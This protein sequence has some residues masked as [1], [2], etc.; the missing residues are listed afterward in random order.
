MGEVVSYVKEFIDELLA[1]AEI[2]GSDLI[3][4]KVNGIIITLPLANPDAVTQAD[5][6]ASIASLVDA[7]PDLL[8]TLNELSAALGD[9]PNFATTM[10]TSLAAKA[11][12]AAVQAELDAIVAS[13][14]IVGSNNQVD[15]YQ[16]VLADAGKVVEI[17]KATAVNLTV[18]T[19]ATVAFPIGTVIEIWQQGAGQVTVVAAG[20]VTIR[21]SE[22][23]LKIYGQYSGAS[24]RKRAA[25]EWVLVGDLVA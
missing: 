6:D 18:P 15:N 11:D 21:S 23:K 3:L 2:V 16:P 10:T 1:N 22:G 17:N 12:D 19:D 14:A 20:G 4:T 25:D 7:S 8:N 9:D 24:L 5:V 13:L